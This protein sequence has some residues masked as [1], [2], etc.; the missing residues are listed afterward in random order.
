MTRLRFYEHFAVAYGTIWLVL[1]VVALLTQSNINTG[2]FG[3]FGFPALALIYAF[4]RR[5]QSRQS[6]GDS[7][8]QQ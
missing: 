7:G 2:A 3:M 8:E 1:M 6:S 4:F 5:S